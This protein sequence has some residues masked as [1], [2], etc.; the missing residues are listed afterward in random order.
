MKLGEMNHINCPRNLS[1]MGEE[2]Q[3]E[4]ENCALAKFYREY[5]VVGLGPIGASDEMDALLS[6]VKCNSEQSP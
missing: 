3:R 6:E 1:G 5:A 4:S 2:A